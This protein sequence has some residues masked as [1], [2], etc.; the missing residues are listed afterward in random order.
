VVFAE[1]KPTGTASDGSGGHR[2]GRDR[3]RGVI[4]GLHEGVA[5]SSVR[6]PT[7]APL[8]LEPLLASPASPYVRVRGAREPRER[9]APET[10]SPTRYVRVVLDVNDV[11][12]RGELIGTFD[13]TKT[14]GP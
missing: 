7:L 9:T 2:L 13:L 14:R 6:N 11:T 5:P 1:N 12:E 8:L 4:P 3:D 10:G